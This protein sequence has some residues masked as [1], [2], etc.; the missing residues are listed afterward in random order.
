MKPADGSTVI[1]KSVTIR[2]ELTGSEDLVL[3]GNLEGSISLGDN[4]LT[5]GPNARVAA[6]IKARNL[7]V[8]GTL[9]GTLRVSGRVDLRHS[10]RVEG[11]I[12][13][14]RLS[15]EENALL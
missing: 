11:D 9:K 14:G 15:I 2:G 13:G 3:D 4:T 7:I 12:F 5:V 6:D 1:G 10:A 8:F